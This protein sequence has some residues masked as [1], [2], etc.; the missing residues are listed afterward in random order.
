LEE[1]QHK[2]QQ[3]M[4]ALVDLYITYKLAGGGNDA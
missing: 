4:E 3:E 2:A 1:K